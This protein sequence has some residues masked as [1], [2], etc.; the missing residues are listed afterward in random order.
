MRLFWFVMA[1]IGVGLIQA[2]L[3]DSSGSGFGIENDSFSR[4]VALG[5]LGTVLAAGALGAGRNLGDTARSL[6]I[7]VVIILGF[8]AAYQYRYELQD[9]A[10]RV[11]AG[12]VPGSPLS[13]GN[14]DGRATV[15]LEKAANGHFEA[16]ISVDGASIPMVIDTGAT[17]SV[18]TAG[19]AQLAGFDTSAL[20]F[21]VPVQTANGI[22]T[23]AAMRAEEISIGG[24]LRKNLAVLVTQPGQ[25]G[26]SLLGMN[27]IGTL[28][29]F[30]VRGD[31]MTLRD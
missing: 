16:W 10:S 23:A 9:F 5:A 4:L 17:T 27:F 8:I 7:W 19:D 25:L 30:D 1:L 14:E 22:A 2:M 13:I 12:L 24:I 31:R 20:N 6:A 11:T 28:S 29:G 15:T 3:N 26:T 21:S 18:L